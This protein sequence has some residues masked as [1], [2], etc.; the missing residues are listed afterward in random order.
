MTLL[1]TLGIE[2]SC[3][4]TAVAVLDAD[5]RIESEAIASQASS[6]ARYG[7]VV[8]ELASRE[9]LQALPWLMDRA[10]AATARPPE[11]VAVTAGP[12]LVGALLVGVR[13]A[14]AFAWGRSLPLVA[15]DHLEAHLASPFL[16]SD[17]G[18]A[19]SMPERVLA[20]V[21]SG[22]HSSWYLVDETGSVGP[23]TTLRARASTR[24]R[25]RSACRTRADRWSTGSPA[26]VTPGPCRCRG[27]GSP[28]A[29]S[30][31]RSPG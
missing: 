2:T 25:R 9:H 19:A 28:T 7:G 8:P 17:G 27:R 10:L 31:F 30:T 29:A 13:Y 22:G 4:E 23:G 15:V 20:L 1:R 11:L 24:W 26:P 21:A 14:A 3:D 5:G 12:G 18:P 16:D 6:H